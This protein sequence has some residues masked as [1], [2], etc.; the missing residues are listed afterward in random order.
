MHRDVFTDSPFVFETKITGASICIGGVLGDTK[1]TG[2]SLNGGISMAEEVVG[3]EATGVLN[4]HYSFRGIMIAGLRNKVTTG[5]GLQ[6]GL[7]NTCRQGQVVQI[8]LIN[9]IGKR[10]TPIVNFSFRRKP[11]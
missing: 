3:V 5:R 10:I 6:I 1:I 9:R 8:G 4:L 2:L 7:F 11:A